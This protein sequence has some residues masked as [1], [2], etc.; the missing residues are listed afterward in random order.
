ME[1]SI[2]FNNMNTTIMPCC[3]QELCH[4]CYCQIRNGGKINCPFC[5]KT[6][7]IL[8]PNIQYFKGIQI[9][10]GDVPEITDNE[11]ETLSELLNLEIE[12]TEIENINENDL[13]LLQIKN[14]FYKARV[15]RKIED[16]LICDNI[17]VIHREGKTYN[18]FPSMKNFNIIDINH[19]YS[20]F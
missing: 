18:G 6:K 7:E 20:L 3:M 9:T 2:C 15:I 11:L 13:V 10:K 1:C 8:E 19:C 12:E 17:L 16:R 5:R 4:S 14:I